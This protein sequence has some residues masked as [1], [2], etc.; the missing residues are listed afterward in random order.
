MSLLIDPILDVKNQDEL[1]VGSALR[2]NFLLLFNG[3]SE[4]S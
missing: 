3:Y 2:L 4:I 1:L